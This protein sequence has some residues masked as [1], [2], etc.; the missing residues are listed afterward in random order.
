M[1]TKTT[2][3]SKVRED[4]DGALGDLRTAMHAV[5]AATEAAIDQLPEDRPIIPLEVRLAAII[6]NIRALQGGERYVSE[7]A[8]FDPTPD[9]VAYAVEH[10]KWCQYANEERGVFRFRFDGADFRVHRMNK[11][12]TL[13]QSS[14]DAA[15]AL[16]ESLHDDYIPDP[17]TPAD[18]EAYEATRPADHSAS[19]FASD[20]GQGHRTRSAEEALDAALREPESFVSTFKDELL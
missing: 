5:R 6:D 9:L 11:D 15:A 17:V 14:A 16:L 12:G 3:R 20:D 18:L 7:V 8:L 2:I 13:A 10:G 19:G 1:T 4:L